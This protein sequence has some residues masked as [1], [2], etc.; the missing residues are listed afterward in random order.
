MVA[1]PTGPVDQFLE[2]AARDHV[3]VGHAVQIASPIRIQ[4]V[5]G[6]CMRSGCLTRPGGRFFTAAR[7]ISPLTSSTSQIQPVCRSN[8]STTLERVA[9]NAWFRFKERLR[10]SAMAH[11]GSRL[12]I[13]PGEHLGIRNGT[14]SC[15]HFK[16]N[17]LE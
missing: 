10:A 14:G 6:A 16:R 15:Y 8:T 1:Q 3:N 11:S 2:A 9:S 13:A 5:T 12:A 7:V 17:N 4:A